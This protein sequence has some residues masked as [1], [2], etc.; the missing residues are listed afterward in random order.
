MVWLFPVFAGFLLGVLWFEPM[1]WLYHHLPG[2]LPTARRW[3]AQLSL[4][5]S[6]SL[7][8][9]GIGDWNPPVLCFALQGVWETG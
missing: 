5:L 2:S 7:L 3:L 9:L 4:S 8:I 1:L 6:R